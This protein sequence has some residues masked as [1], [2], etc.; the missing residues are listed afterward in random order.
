MSSIEKIRCLNSAKTCLLLSCL[1]F[2][3]APIEIEYGKKQHDKCDY[4]HDNAYLV[5]NHDTNNS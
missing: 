3:V 2:A 4:H 1:C 5:S